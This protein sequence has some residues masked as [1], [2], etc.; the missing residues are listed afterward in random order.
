MPIVFTFFAVTVSIGAILFA[1]AW[2][3]TRNLTRRSRMWRFLLSSIAALAVAPTIVE[4]C[5]QECICPATYAS[6]MLLA[7]DATRRSIGLAYGVLPL[8]TAAV[9]IFGM[10]SYYVERKRHV[11]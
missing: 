2:L 7:P 6:L 11:V 9:I 8:L 3:P 4:F 10:W 5:G 1:I